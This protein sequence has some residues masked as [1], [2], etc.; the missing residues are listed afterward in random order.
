MP[1]I[2]HSAP[3][4]IIAHD[5]CRCRMILV[6]RSLLMYANNAMIQLLESLSDSIQMIDDE[7]IVNI[8]LGCVIATD[9]D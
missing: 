3:P 7:F 5:R 9:H 8:F 6:F 2:H 1:F 4:S